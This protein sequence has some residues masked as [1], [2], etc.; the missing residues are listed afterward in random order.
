MDFIKKLMASASVFAL[1]AGNAVFAE[2]I[3]LEDIELMPEFGLEEEELTALIEAF[4]EEETEKAAEAEFQFSD[5][6]YGSQYYEP[7]TYLYNHGVIG[8]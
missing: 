8:G 1:L 2:E 7:V 4:L 3:N 5:V 6:V